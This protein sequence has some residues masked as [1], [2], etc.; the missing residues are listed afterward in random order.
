MAIRFHHSGLRCVE[1]K[2]KKKKTF[3]FKGNATG[4]TDVDQTSILKTGCC[5]PRFSWLPYPLGK[6][7]P[8]RTVLILGPVFLFFISIAMLGSATPARLIALVVHEK[9]VAGKKNFY[10]YFRKKSTERERVDNYKKKTKI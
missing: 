8:P 4:E 3:L 2:T 5:S 9:E 1:K 10:Y 7:G 6:Q